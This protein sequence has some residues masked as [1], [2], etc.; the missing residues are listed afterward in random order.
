MGPGEITQQLIA[1]REGDRQALD[2]LFQMVYDQLRRMS[3]GQLGRGGS[4]I[5]LNTT[6]LVHEAYLK[7]VDGRRANWQDRNHFFAV[8]SKAMRQI[9]VDHV[10]QRLAAKRGGGA[11]HTDLEESQIGIEGRVVELLELNDALQR[12]EQLSERLCK[13]VELRFF[14]GLSE[15]EIGRILGVADRTVRRD[16]RKARAFLFSQLHESAPE[17]GTPRGD[18]R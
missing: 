17:P 4:R 9:L 8:A 6:A 7:L 13:V 1:Y 2:R 18:P 3:H 12:L 15:E 11:A 14:G 10:R 16:W 5:T